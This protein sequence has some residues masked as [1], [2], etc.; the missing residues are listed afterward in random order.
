MLAKC[1]LCWHCLD[2]EKELGSPRKPGSRFSELRGRCGVSTW[3]FGRSPPCCGCGCVRRRQRNAF[4]WRHADDIHVRIRTHI[5]IHISA[6]PDHRQRPCPRP[7][8]LQ[9]EQDEQDITQFAATRASTWP[10]ANKQQQEQSRS[11]KKSKTVSRVRLCSL[12]SS[13][14]LFS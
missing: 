14:P 1:L 5:R 4:V 6:T 9:D 10:T 11:Q 13:P 8:A 7:L 12:I 3:S 2:T